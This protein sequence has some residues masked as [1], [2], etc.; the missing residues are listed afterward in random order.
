MAKKKTWIRRHAKDIVID[1]GIVF[2]VLILLTISGMF[3]WISTLEIPDLSSFDQR[4]I[5][6]ST[7]IYDKTGEILLYDLHQNVRRTIV[8]FEE[9]SYHIKNASVAI[10]DDTFYTHAGVRPM[11]IF[12]SA[13]N[14]IRSGKGVFGGAGGSTITQQVIKNSILGQER[15]VTRKIR[16]AI[17]AIKLEKVLTKD[18]ILGYYLNESPYG[19]TIYGVEEAS[20]SFFGKSA[21]DVT[22]AQAAYLAALPQRPTFFSPHGNNTDALSKRQQL[23]LKRMLI[24]EFITQ[25]EYEEAKNTDVEFL[26][27]ATKGIRAPHFVMYIREQ[28]VEKYGEKVLSEKG[29]KVI[30]TL[31]WSLQQEAE[32]IVKDGV[33]LIEERFNASNAGLVATNPQT[34]DV[35]VMVGSRD[36]FST[37]IDGNFNVTLAQ[38]QPGSAI[39]PIVYAAAFNLGYTP[40]TIVF[41]TKTQFST[42]CHVSNKTSIPPC[43]SPNNHNN[44]FLGP[45]TLRNALAQSLNI[46]AVKVLYLAGIQNSINLSNDLGITT[47]N[48]PDRLGLTLVL[49]GGEVTLMEKTSA[50]GVFANEGVKS[51]RRTILRIEDNLGEVI[52][53]AQTRSRRVLSRDVSL[54]I[55][56]ILSDNESRVPLWG[57]NSLVYFPNRDV[58]SKTGST[59]NLRDAWIIG[60]TPNLSVGLWVGNND[61]SP[62]GGG[63]SGLI[64]TPIWREFMDI[65]L[66]QTKKQ[67]FAQAP[68]TPNNIKPILRGQTV[69]TY[70]LIQR[71]QAGEADLGYRSI[72]DNMHSIL[73]FVYKR[74]PRGPYPSNPNLDPQYAAWEYGVNRW[75]NQAFE[76]L[77]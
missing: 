54:Q 28:L 32:R 47:L 3:I 16:E 55:S 69:D 19:G 24:N 68:D 40:D 42:A 10:E 58:A 34:G 6:Q 51:Q 62:M 53:E 39:K 13:V 59:N 60:Y 49:G 26:P 57:R 25:E 38:R 75:K 46:P 33:N 30:T 20:R 65:A 56:D 18:Q 52:Y 2:F 7:R 50:Y 45:V 37:E 41:D 5:L 21:S 29:F 11:A 70:T 12:R 8:P 23:V 72:T 35:L 43:Y 77:F 61:N 76:S 66:E 15:T 36:Y 1:T 63:L 48:D 64:A 31:D 27:R 73:H 71:I 9:I 17:L 22:L 67:S 4:K 74:N 44:K 14:N